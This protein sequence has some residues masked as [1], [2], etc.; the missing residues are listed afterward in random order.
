[1][2]NTL[3]TYQSL[4]LW[5]QNTLLDQSDGSTCTS[6]LELPRIPVRENVCDMSRRRVTGVLPVFSS[7]CIYI[8]VYSRSFSLLVKFIGVL[9]ALT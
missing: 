2:R 9:P 1:M 4:K 3:A 5:L 6:S 8:H 7:S